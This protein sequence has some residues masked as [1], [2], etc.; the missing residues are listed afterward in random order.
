M[1]VEHPDHLQGTHD[2]SDT[3]LAFYVSNATSNAVISASD[4]D[5]LVIVMKASG[6]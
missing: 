2:E 4:T 1:I 6:K 5:V 3:L